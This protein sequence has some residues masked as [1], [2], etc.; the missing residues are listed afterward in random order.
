MADTTTTTQN[1]MGQA[2]RENRS[3]AARHSEGGLARP[4]EEYTARLPSDTFLWAA[5]ASIAAS[6]TLMAAG[7]R[8]G[9]L[10]VGQW[11]PTF[12]LLGV[13]NKIVKVAGPDR[14]S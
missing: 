4:I 1:Q 11:A 12:L 8:N 6:L 3:E 5:G 10:F 2:G 7:N 13:Y 9:A 14:L